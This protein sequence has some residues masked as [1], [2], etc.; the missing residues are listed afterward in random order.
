MKAHLYD[1]PRDGGEIE[2][3]HPAP[4]IKVLVPEQLAPLPVSVRVPAPGRRVP[5]ANYR[6][7][8]GPSDQLVYVFNH[9]D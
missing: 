8:I 9:M 3:Y 1:G 5:V 2:L 7:A 6:R 4:W